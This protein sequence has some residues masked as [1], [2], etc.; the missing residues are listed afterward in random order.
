MHLSLVRIHRLA[1]VAL[2][3]VIC[4]VVVS[5][6]GSSSG[7]SSSSSSASAASGGTGGSGSAQFAKYQACL[8]SHGVTLPAFHHRTNGSS[9]GS[10][11]GSATTPSGGSGGPPAG[12]GGGFFGG[13]GG[14]GRGTN[15]AQSAKFKAASQACAKDLPA[16]ARTGR[17]GQG[18][19][20]GHFDAATLQKFSACVKQH[21][22]TLPKPNTSGSG[23]V[24]PRSIEKNATFEKAAKAC[25]SDL[26]PSAPS[27]AG[28]P[29]AS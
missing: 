26:R 18:R 11:S 6:C 10:S 19:T 1:A 27:A 20:D 5:A 25:Q 17:F 28:S 9:S 23:P 21:G 14:G 4:A 8:K 24:F 16:G 29:P 22:Y 13:G 2:L 12:G 15:P 3:T 7:S